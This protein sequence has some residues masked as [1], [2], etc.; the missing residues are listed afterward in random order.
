MS[1]EITIQEGQ[2][3]F[4]IAIL[5]Y[6]DVEGLFLFIDDNNIST[7]NFNLSV[8]EKY[9]I[10]SAPINKEVVDYYKSNGMVVTSGFNPFNSRAF[11]AGYSSG[12]R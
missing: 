11:S 8:G 9:K 2:T 10:V 6:G 12:Y 5:H 1:N 7:V 3:L 4:D